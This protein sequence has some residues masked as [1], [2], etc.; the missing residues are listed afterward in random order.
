[1]PFNLNAIIVLKI[2]KLTDN[3]LEISTM[4]MEM[5]KEIKKL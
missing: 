3:V 5:T 1:M 2:S 4:T